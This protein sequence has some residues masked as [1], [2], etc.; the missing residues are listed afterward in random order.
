MSAGTTHSERQLLIRLAYGALWHVQVDTSFEQG[1]DLSKARKLILKH[2]TTEKQAHGIELARIALANHTDAGQPWLRT[3][4][5][6]LKGT[7]NAE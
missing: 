6:H 4:D 5:A 7:D 3:Y 1:R 2:L